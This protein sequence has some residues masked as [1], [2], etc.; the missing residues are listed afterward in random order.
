MSVTERITPELQQA[1]IR[2]QQ[3]Q[4]QLGQVITEKNFIVS[5]LT[6]INRALEVLN[7]ID[8]EGVVYKNVGHVM[9]KV[10]RD[11]AIKELS[12]RKELLELRLKSVE[13]QEQLL[14]NQLSEVQSRINEYVSRTYG[15]QAK[16]E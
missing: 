3:I 8:P 16:A 14:R 6:E 7:S 5:E 15:K 9:V 2:Y 11:D 13:K 4:N 10:K 1:L 12:D